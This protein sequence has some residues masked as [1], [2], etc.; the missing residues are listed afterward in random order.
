[1]RPLTGSTFDTG[2]VGVVFALI[3]AGAVMLTGTVPA[4]ETGFVTL[5]T[6]DTPMSA[7]TP[8]TATVPVTGGAEETATVP[9]TAALTELP[10]TSTGEAIPDT[11]TAPM[12]ATPPGTVTSPDVGTTV[13]TGTGCPVTGS[14]NTT[15]GNAYPLMMISLGYVMPWLSGALRARFAGHAALP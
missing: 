13:V 3:S 2:S 15:A 12:M 10:L 6:W 14:T 5:V 7:A 11:A 1:M 9:V 4:I 8:D